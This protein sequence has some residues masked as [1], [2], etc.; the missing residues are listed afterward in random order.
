MTRFLAAVA[1]CACAGCATRLPFD[2]LP[3]SFTYVHYVD[4]TASTGRLVEKGSALHDA[5][6]E[7]LEGN[8]GGWRAN[9]RAYAPG[10][11]FKSNG[12]NVMCN[13]GVVVVEH[14]LHGSWSQVAKVIKDCDRDLAAAAQRR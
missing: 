13:A 11:Y 4:G 7:M 14:R 8:A 12:V 1:L 6:R 9:A 2:S 10:H 5:L 3:D